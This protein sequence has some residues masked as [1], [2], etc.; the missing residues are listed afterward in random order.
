MSENTLFSSKVNDFPDLT[1]DPSDSALWNG[2]TVY[3]KRDWKGDL[4]VSSDA[5]SNTVEVSSVW[6]RYYVWFRFKCG[7]DQLNARPDWGP[8]GPVMNLWD[9]DV[10]EVFIRRP[11]QKGY[12]EFEASPLGQWLDVKILEPRVLVDFEWQS[13]LEVDVRLDQEKKSWVTIFRIP[14]IVFYDEIPSA[15]EK[16]DAWR[17]NFFRILGREPSRTFLSW[18]PTFTESADFHVPDA[19][20]NLIFV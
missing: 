14:F 10:V 4:Q 20:G 19:F 16:G 18:R 11:G 1:V 12:F 15:P 5:P 17:V 2:G 9:A 6:N 3:I 13:G 7:F 8:D